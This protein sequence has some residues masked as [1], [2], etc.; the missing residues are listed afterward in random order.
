[1]WMTPIPAMTEHM[2]G[3]RGPFSQSAYSAP[4]KAHSVCTQSRRL[5]RVSFFHISHISERTFTARP[6]V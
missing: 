1:M 6:S 4:D 3:L 5:I 2:R